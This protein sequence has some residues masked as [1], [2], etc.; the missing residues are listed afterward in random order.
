MSGFWKSAALTWVL[1]AVVAAAMVLAA[2][3]SGNP[4]TVDPLPDWINTGSNV[5]CLLIAGAVVLPRTRILGA[6]AGAAMMV[7]SMATNYWVD[8]PQYF[9]HVL[10]FNL[11]TLGAALLILWRSRQVQQV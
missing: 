8:G 10:P 9:L 1:C 6:G 5:L 4:A 11:V 2:M 3:G 7:V